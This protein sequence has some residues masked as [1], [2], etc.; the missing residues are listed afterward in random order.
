VHKAGSRK[1]KAK[2]SVEFGAFQLQSGICQF[3]YLVSTARDPDFFSAL[4]TTLM[5]QSQPA[6]FIHLNAV[7]LKT[8]EP[9]CA[10]RYQTTSAMLRAFQ[11]VQQAVS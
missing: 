6:D 11:V 1:H 9:D 7:I 2:K 10:Q 4:S 5:E 8:C 3:G